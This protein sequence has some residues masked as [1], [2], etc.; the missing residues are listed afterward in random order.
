MGVLRLLVG[1][2]LCGQGGPF[3][4]MSDDEVIEEGTRRVS[5]G[6]RKGMPHQFFFQILYS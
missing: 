6:A 2:P 3:K 1:E 4:G 5:N